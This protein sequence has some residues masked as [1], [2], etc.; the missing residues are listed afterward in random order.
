MD[1][2]KLDT[3]M[4]TNDASDPELTLRNLIEHV[5]QSCE[6]LRPEYGSPLHRSGYLSNA[7]IPKTWSVV[8]LSETKADS[9]P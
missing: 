5:N 4:R 3:F 9:D 8:P 7:V 2:L 1:S 6:R